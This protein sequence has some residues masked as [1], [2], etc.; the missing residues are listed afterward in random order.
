MTR[1]ERVE[2]VAIGVL[3]QLI[4]GGPSDLGAADTM[5]NIFM[6]NLV[7]ALAGELA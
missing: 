3:Q 7:A 6:D 5:I 4:K 1:P 2:F